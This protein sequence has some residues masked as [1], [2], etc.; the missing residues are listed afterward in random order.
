[1]IGESF[2]DM[3]EKP[4][5]KGKRRKGAAFKKGDMIGLDSKGK[6]VKQKR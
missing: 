6:A 2:F 5:K 3:A 4:V 1:M